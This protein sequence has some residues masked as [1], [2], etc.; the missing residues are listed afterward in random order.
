MSYLEPTYNPNSCLCRCAQCGGP[1]GTGKTLAYSTF[2]R[3][4]AKERLQIANPTT[5][6]QP[7]GQSSGHNQ[8]DSVQ[9][10]DL[11]D[12]PCAE[13]R[14]VDQDSD[15]QNDNNAAVLQLLIIIIIVF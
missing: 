11:D 6:Q 5:A 2:K 10:M 9:A 14:D 8:R 3:H 4:Q 1:F 15:I 12:E 7:V 13:E